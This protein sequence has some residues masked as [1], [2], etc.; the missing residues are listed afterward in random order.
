MKINVFWVCKR[1]LNTFFKIFSCVM[2]DCGCFKFKQR[3]KVQHFVT[4]RKGHVT[5]REQTNAV[6]SI[7]WLD[8]YTFDNAL[9]K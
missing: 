9:K 6:V 4:A 7:V 8:V 5:P 2:R 1:L 3:I